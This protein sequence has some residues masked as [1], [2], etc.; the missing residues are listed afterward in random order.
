LIF[1]GCGLAKGAAVPKFTRNVGAADTGVFDPSDCLCL[2]GGSQR[3]HGPD[4]QHP[5][6]DLI[7]LSTCIIGQRKG[8]S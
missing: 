1:S 7:D 3:Q 8:P 5:Q 6:P 2:I 4:R